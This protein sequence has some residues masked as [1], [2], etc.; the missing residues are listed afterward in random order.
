MLFWCPLYYAIGGHRTIAV[1]PGTLLVVSKND[2]IYRDEMSSNTNAKRQIS[3]EHRFC[4]S[5]VLCA[6]FS[7]DFVTH[8]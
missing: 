7:R 6:Q 4:Q 5:N 2:M 1:P 3:A 8:M